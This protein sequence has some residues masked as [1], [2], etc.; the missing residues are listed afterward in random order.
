MPFV[1]QQSVLCLNCYVT[2]KE[3][4]SFEMRSSAVICLP[5]DQLC[6][7]LLSSFAAPLGFI[8]LV[9][10]VSN[11][12]PKWGCPCQ[13]FPFYP[14]PISYSKIVFYC[15]EEH[16]WRWKDPI[17][18]QNYSPWKT[19]FISGNYLFIYASLKTSFC[20]VYQSVTRTKEIRLWSGDVAGQYFFL[21]EHPS[22]LWSSVWIS[23]PH[24]AH[25]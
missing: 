8:Q 22:S 9:F 21:L 18:P 10:I 11:F 25:T 2:A 6:C 13:R 24:L 3:D 19:S 15:Q 20:S 17:P 14:Q 1:L 16:T 5:W 23:C 4:E 12:L 7:D